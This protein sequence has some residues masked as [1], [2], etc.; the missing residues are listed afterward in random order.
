LQ[1]IS[2]LER[3]YKFATRQGYSLVSTRLV[4]PSTGCD[5]SEGSQR[6]GVNCDGVQSVK[7]K[8]VN[9]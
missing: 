6:I 5:V 7:Y 4:T 9:M 8:Y 3:R 1:G 2:Y